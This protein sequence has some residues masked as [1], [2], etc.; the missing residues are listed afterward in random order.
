M[1]KKLLKKELINKELDEYIWKTF[2]KWKDD[3]TFREGGNG[4]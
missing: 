4:K 1:L 2:L 3:K